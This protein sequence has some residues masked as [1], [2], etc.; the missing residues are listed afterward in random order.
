[1][2]T[3]VYNARAHDLPSARAVLFPH[4]VL[5]RAKPGLIAVNARGLRFV[6]EA[7]SY[8][9]FVD[10]MLASPEIG[11]RKPAWLICDAAFIWLYGLGLVRP[12][13][14]SL[15]RHLKAGY[16]RRASTLLE[17]AK[18]I[19]VDPAGLADTVARHNGFAAT[20]RDEEF[21]RGSTRLNRQNGDSSRSPNPCLAPIDRSPFYAVAVWPADLAAS[22]GIRTDA[23]ARVLNGGGEAIAGLYAIG[24]DMASIMKGTYPGPGTTLGPA[25][26]FGYR[27]VQHMHANQ[28]ATASS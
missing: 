22:A 2:P 3:S 6:N 10:A 12:W 11:P 26:V 5:D 20:G 1:M 27:A 9:E 21:G 7:S 15:R 24:N 25:I 28:H 4:I 18:D 19:G 14:L 23:D 17:L 8:H 16:L 13:Q